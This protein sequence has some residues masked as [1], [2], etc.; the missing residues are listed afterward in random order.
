MNFKCDDCN[1]ETKYKSAYE[2][3]TKTKKHISQ[4]KVEVV[5]PNEVEVIQPN[6]VEEIKQLTGEIEKCKDEAGK[7]EK[8]L[9]EKC[10]GLDKL[11]IEK[12]LVIKGKDK[13]IKALTDKLHQERKVMKA[14]ELKNSKNPMEGIPEDMLKFMLNAVGGGDGVKVRGFNYKRTY[15][16]STPPPP[17]FD[18]TNFFNHDDDATGKKID[19]DDSDN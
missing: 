13:E 1:F 9:K 11:L 5:V 7:M 2:K 19:D 16:G 3:H 15:T 4:T 6:Y 12:D 10:A 17:I 14:K 8:E 18:A